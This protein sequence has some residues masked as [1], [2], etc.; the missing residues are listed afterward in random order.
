M[1]VCWG[2]MPYAH[3]HACKSQG[4]STVTWE[5]LVELSSLLFLMRFL[6]VFMFGSKH[7]SSQPFHWPQ[8]VYTI[9]TDDALLY[10]WI[11]STNH[12]QPKW[13]TLVPNWPS[14]TT[15]FPATLF[16]SFG[17]ALSKAPHSVIVNTQ[18]EQSSPLFK[19]DIKSKLLRCWEEASV[20]KLW[21]TLS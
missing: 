19:E 17:T 9:C 18:Q 11:H 7:S 3:A 5:W 10:T 1:C 21:R 20:S 8:K 6:Q 4:T 15:K 13:L 2:G 14:P 16:K 12:I